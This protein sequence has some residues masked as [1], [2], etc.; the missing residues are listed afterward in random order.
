MKIIEKK[1]IPISEAKDI[2]KNSKRELYEQKLAYEY[3]KQFAKLKPEKAKELIEKLKALDI[4]KLKDEMI[5]KIVDILPESVDELR[6]LLT[7][8]ELTF[9]S[10][11]INKIYDV[12]KEYI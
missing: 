10:D 2:L 4:P 1:Y 9:K 11:E 6:T 8:S 7:T 5:I 3:V 12:V